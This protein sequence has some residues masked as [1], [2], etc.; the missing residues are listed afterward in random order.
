MILKILE[1]AGLNTELVFDIGCIITIGLILLQILNINTFKGLYL[2]MIRAKTGKQNMAIID[3]GG[4]G[5]D[6]INYPRS[7]NSIDYKYK[8]DQYNWPIPD[9]MEKI[10]PNDVRFI[11]T[12]TQ[13]GAAYN[14]HIIGEN[15]QAYKKMLSP[16]MQANTIDD[17]A[18]EITDRLTADISKPMIYGAALGFIIICAV[19]GYLLLMKGM[20][21]NVAKHA[22]EAARSIPTTTIPIPPLD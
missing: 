22:F 19:F 1:A 20:E 10:L 6:V 14:I 21:Y 4:I 15:A 2:P 12:S 7:S 11:Q 8:D 13:Y 16:K 17:R 3:L 9:N 18:K 5:V